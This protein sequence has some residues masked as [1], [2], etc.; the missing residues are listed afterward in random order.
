MNVSNRIEELRQERGWTEYQLAKE[1]GIA[2]SLLT[3]LKN[4][5]NNPSLLTL[6][7]I[8]NGMDI[9][10]S[11]FFSQDRYN[12]A[13]LS[14]SQYKLIKKW[15]RLSKTQKEKIMIYIDGMLVS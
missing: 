8:C 13:M 3:N 6:E 7:N 1:A 4:R 14:D 12:T 9:T 10:L 5:G 2:Q 15:E 11:Q